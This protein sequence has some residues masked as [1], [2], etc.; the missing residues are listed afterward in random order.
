MKI[1]AKLEE[2]G[3]VLPDPAKPPPGIELP[4]ALARVAGDRAY[5]SGHG[6]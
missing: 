6:P 5:L 1:E 2:L 4:L 3:L